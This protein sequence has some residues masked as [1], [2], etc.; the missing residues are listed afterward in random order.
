MKILQVLRVARTIYAALINKF[1]KKQTE[2]KHWLDHSL[3]EH[4]CR[5]NKYC[6]ATK[7][8]AK[9]ECAQVKFIL[10]FEKIEVAQTQEVLVSDVKALMRMIVMMLP[11][12]MFWALYD[13]Q[14]KCVARMSVLVRVRDHVLY[15]EPTECRRNSFAKRKIIL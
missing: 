4:D 12:P 15:L 2:R 10:D 6:L 1:C 3:D 14:V 11:I 7:R 5:G 9:G 13:Q 8:T